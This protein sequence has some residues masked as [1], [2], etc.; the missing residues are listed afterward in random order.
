MIDRVL[1]H[2]RILKILQEGKKTI[3]EPAHWCTGHYAQNKDG[4]PVNSLSNEAVQ[5][6]SIGAIEKSSQTNECDFDS[7]F[8]EALW[9][10]KEAVFDVIGYP[11]EDEEY[12]NISAIAEY[13]DTCSHSNLMSVMENA[14]QHCA[15]VLQQERLWK[16]R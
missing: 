7:E 16:L 8:S 5:W 14:I 1:H 10:V 4:I 3:S 12:D 9:F 15:T 13:N 11:D 2:E 6:C